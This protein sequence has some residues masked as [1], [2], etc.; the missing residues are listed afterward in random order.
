MCRCQAIVI[1]HFTLLKVASAESH[2]WTGSAGSPLTAIRLRLRRRLALGTLRSNDADGNAK[3][4]KTV[5]FMIEQAD[6]I[7][8]LS[9]HGYGPY[10]FN[11]RR[12][13]LHSTK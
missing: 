13:R 5:G 3:V 7:F 4:E 6:E 12:V 10:E 11:S 8:S 9:E 2:V 1:G